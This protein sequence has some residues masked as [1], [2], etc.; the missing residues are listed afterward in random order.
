MRRKIS[1]N[2]GFTLVE[3][4]AVVVILLAISVIAITSISAAVERN[5]KKQDAAKQEVIVG[6]AKLYYDQHKNISRFTDEHHPFKNMI[7]LSDLNLEDSEGHY[8]DGSPIC[9]RVLVT[10]NGTS[11]VVK[12]EFQPA[13]DT[14]PYTG[15]GYTIAACYGE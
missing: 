2:W 3:L 15:G 10:I 4:L 14:A 13:T 5:K 6:Y 8:S 12:F 9:G 11:G 7:F 1:N